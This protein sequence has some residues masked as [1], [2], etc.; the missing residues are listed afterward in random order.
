VVRFW[1]RE[2]D[3]PA[4]LL[5]VSSIGRNDD[6]VVRLEEQTTA[7]ALTYGLKGAD[8]WVG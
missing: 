1:G 8:G 3:F 6:F 2:A 4:M 7:K 5:A